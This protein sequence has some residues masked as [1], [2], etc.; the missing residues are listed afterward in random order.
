[1]EGCLT[2]HSMNRKYFIVQFNQ[3]GYSDGFLITMLSH[4]D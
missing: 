2:D 4:T 3:G 1:M